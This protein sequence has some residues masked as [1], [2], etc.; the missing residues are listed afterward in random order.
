M[1]PDTPE[2]PVMLYRAACIYYDHGHLDRA[3]ALFLEV[4]EK[5]TKHEL[6]PASASQYIAALS[7]ECKTSE[8]LAAVRR[9]IDMPGI[10][11][12]ASCATPLL[13]LRPI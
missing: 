6:A 2:M 10:V 4:V 12:E 11:R 8:I 13:K 1:V 9:F 3:E 5:H 7:T